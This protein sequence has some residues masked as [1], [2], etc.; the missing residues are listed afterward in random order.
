MSALPARAVQRAPRPRRA[1]SVVP[2]VPTGSEPYLN[3]ELSWLNYNERVLAL[4]EARDA[5]L[6]ERVR[7]L[8]I[9]ASNTD[10]FYMVRVAGLKRQEAAGLG[11]ARSMDGLTATRQLALISE[12][13]VGQ[14]ERHARLFRDEIRPAMAEAGLRI[15]RWDELSAEQREAL[16]TLFD[17][18]I[19]PVLTPLAVDPG[20]PFPYISNLSLNLA[21][22][23][24]DPDGDRVHFARVKVP[25]LLGRFVSPEEGV[26]V[27]LEDVIAAHL[28][29]L[30]PGMRVVEH[31]AFRVTR[32]GDLEVDDDGAEDLLEALEDELRKR[33]FGPAVRLEVEASMPSHVLELLVRELQ[34]AAADVHSLPGPLNLAGL[35]ELTSI[36]RA[37]L[38]DEPMQPV[39]PAALI[40]TDEVEVDMFAVLRRGD[41]L[42]HHPYESFVSSTQRFIE[43]AADDPQVLAI[44]Q[45][46]YRTSGD[47]PIVDALVRAAESGKQV[48][49]LVEIKARFD[50]QNNIGW[51]RLLERSGCHVVY[52]VIGLKTHAKLCLVVREEAGQLRRYVHVGTGNYNP[53]TARIYEDVGLLTSSPVLGADVSSLFNFL[54]GYSRHTEYRTLLVAP[55][56]LRPRLLA[57]IRRE[58][59]LATPEEPGYICLKVNNLID[60]ELIDALYLASRQGVAIDLIVRS[61]CA[62][63]P[64]IKGQSETIR[65]RSIVGRFLEHSRILWFGNGGQPEVYIG[66]ADLMHRNLDRRVEAVVRV[67]D[68]SAR[69]H[70]MAVLK[71]ALRD[72]GAWLL[73]S[74]GS[75]A[76]QELLDDQPEFLLQRRLMGHA[77]LDD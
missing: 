51:A 11:Q 64:G 36:D 37:D 21:V 25:P 23:V 75:W 22:Q 46:L 33:R 12:R 38:K 60:E 3:R 42:V 61:I 39:T 2:R 18:R 70:L 69:A 34:V 67:E 44:K 53:S 28:D 49:V 5:P 45:T 13:V 10:E 24:G 31:H 26:L 7:F 41:I 30:F 76:R 48:V 74:D 8:S 54:T 50:E 73:T 65:V 55:H 19:F 16:D 35:M 72:T 20:H 40:S 58:A 27:P 1:P 9:F 63:R 47:S 77:V 68:G 32:N 56:A 15:T 6:L 4:A 59:E 14:V 57:L 62:L 43:Q 29:R 66:S 52:G 17:D 71:M